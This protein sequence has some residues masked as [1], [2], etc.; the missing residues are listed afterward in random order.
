LQRPL[1]ATAHN[2]PPTNKQR[3][4]SHS[5]PPLID[6]IALDPKPKGLARPL[7]WHDGYLGLH[8]N[9]GGGTATCT[10]GSL[11]ARHA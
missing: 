1:L 6:G 4:S 2:L 8:H 3:L 5:N 9:V 10:T 11:A 7:T